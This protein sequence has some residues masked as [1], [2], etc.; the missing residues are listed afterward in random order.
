MRVVGIAPLFVG[1]ALVLANDA[2]AEEATFSVD[3]LSFVHFE[4]DNSSALVPGGGR[5]TWS[6]TPASTDSWSVSVRPESFQLPAMT[7]PSGRRV[8]WR[9]SGPAT[10]TLSRSIN[11]IDCVLSAPLVAYVDGSRT[12]I[13]F[14]LTFTTA[15]VSVRAAG[16]VAA[17]QGVRLD[18][19]SGQLQLVAAGVSPIGAATAPGKPFYVVLSGQLSGLPSGLRSP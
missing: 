9:L 17:T 13:D 16:L 11:G 7:Y 4:G 12:G 19:A 8:V 18:A 1:L 2:W 6:L 10:G 5:M 3:S 15:P 14:P